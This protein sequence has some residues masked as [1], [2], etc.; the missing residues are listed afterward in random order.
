[1]ENQTGIIV[2]TDYLK[3]Y[4][5]D[6][7]LSESQFAETIGVARSTVNRILNGKRN[8]GSKFVAGVLKSYDDLTFDSVFSYNKQLPKGK[9]KEVV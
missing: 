6:N 4:L 1:M 7:K 9:I 2:K 5:S 8:P 3:K